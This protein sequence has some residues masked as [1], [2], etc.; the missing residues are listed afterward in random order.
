MQRPASSFSG[1]TAEQLQE[2]VAAVT[3]ASHVILLEAMQIGSVP[4]FFCPFLD[5]R[6]SLRVS[7]ITNKCGDL[8]TSDLEW[9]FLRAPSQTHAFSRMHQCSSSGTDT[10]GQA[11]DPGLAST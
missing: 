10:C 3:K 1:M 2:K 5:T 8:C 9:D 11:H 7:G 6:I 4:I